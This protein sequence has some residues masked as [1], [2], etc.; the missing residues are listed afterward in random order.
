MRDRNVQAFRGCVDVLIAARDRAD[1]IER[2]VSSALVQDEVRRV[3]V[4]DDGSTDDT[5][6]KARGCDPDG[7]RVIVK[8]LHSSI[9]PAGARNLAVEIS[10]SPW[11][12]ILDGDDFFLP[13]R[14]GNLLSWSDSCDFIADDLLQV[15]EDAADKVAPEMPFDSSVRPRSIDLTQ[16]VLGNI[17]R[18]GAQRRELGF[19]KPLI[20]RSFLRRNALRYDETLRLGE[21]YALYA[22]ALAAGARFLLLPVTG[23]VSLVRVNSLSSQH[24]KQDLER[25]RDSDCEL[26]TAKI[27]TAGERRVIAKHYISIDCRVQWLVMIEA[28]KSRSMA[29]FLAPLFRS[30]EI[31]VFL[32][33]QLLSE[34]VRRARSRL[35]RRGLNQRDNS[36]S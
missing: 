19:V 11:V 28:F 35:A 22:R 24:S 12:A 1:T 27:L 2:A 36:L 32:V 6:V 7:S 23:Y 25:L 33:R 5:A 29:R 10:E 4:V 16:F 21:D 15:P 34:I 17:T 3:I 18:R 13:G 8:S 30:R 14:I 26:M 31:S 9:G 20:R